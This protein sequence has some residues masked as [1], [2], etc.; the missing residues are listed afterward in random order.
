MIGLGTLINM[1]A[2]IVGT[3]VGVLVGG[4]LPQ[5]TRDLIT[6]AL[7]LVVLVVAALNVV[8]LLDADWIA[9]VG[10]AAPLLIV[11][12]SVV[13]GGIIG[14]LLHLEDRVERLGGWVQARVGRVSADDARRSR[15]IEGFVDASLLFC[16]GPLA[17]LGA[18]SDGLGRGIDQLAL[19]S[20]LDGFA[21]IAFA[22][23]LGWGVAFSAIAVGI[24]QGL[25]T[26]L[27]ALVGAVM[28]AS[29]IAAITATGGV[30]LLGVALRLLQVSRLPVADL[31]PALVIAPALTLAV[32]AWR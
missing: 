29:A 23:S 30:L 17:I 12:G 27:G 6:Q 18:L 5:R 28:A 7:G 19:K 26:I 3:A 15:F 16:I 2:I 1:A 8:A 10:D 20:V 13:L 14:S 32:T 4:R 22:A 9:D 24:V 25:F 31:L 11:L 21:S